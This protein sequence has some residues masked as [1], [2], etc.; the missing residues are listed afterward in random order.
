VPPALFFADYAPELDDATVER[1][2][3]TDAADALILVIVTLGERPADATANLLGPIVIN[4]HTRQAVQAVLAG[5]GYD[6]RT[7]LGAG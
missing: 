7:P 2:G 5:S 3:L 4:R 6:L 1:L